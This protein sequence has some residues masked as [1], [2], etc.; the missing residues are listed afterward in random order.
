MKTESAHGRRGADRRAIRHRDAVPLP[1]E[2]MVPEPRIE[3]GW[4]GYQPRPL[5]LR[6]PGETWSAEWDSNPLP[7]VR[8]TGTR[9]DELSAENLF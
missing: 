3:L 8:Q 6:Y 9:P 4:R 2:K 7:S 1:R 5:P